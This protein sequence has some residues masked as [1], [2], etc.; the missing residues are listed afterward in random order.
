M[1]HVTERC[2]GGPD[3]KPR[4]ARS[5][6]RL[7]TGRD[8]CPSEFRSSAIWTWTWEILAPSS[9]SSG[10]QSPN[11][12][13]WVRS[14]WVP[15]ATQRENFAIAR[16]ARRH[17]VVVF[18][19]STVRYPAHWRLVS[20]PPRFSG[21]VDVPRVQQSRPIGPIC[22]SRRRVKRARS[23]PRDSRPLAQEV[24]LVPRPVADPGRP[25][26]PKTHPLPS[27]AR[28]EESATTRR[29]Q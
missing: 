22:A 2:L 9:T 13:L 4:S 18:G 29:T 6:Y 19:A 14:H 1:A 10:R 23:V 12:S 11:S 21:P 28:H 25:V 5:T 24:R 16:V 8:R 17:P 15:N 20:P 26:F 27:V 7:V 3:R